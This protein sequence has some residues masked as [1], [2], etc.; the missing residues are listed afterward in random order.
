MSINVL[1]LRDLQPDGLLPIQKAYIK[2]MIK[3]LVDAQQ[4]GTMQNIQT[5]PKERGTSPNITTLIEFKIPLPVD[6]LYCPALSCT[7]YD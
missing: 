7:V 3:S 5:Q 4:A 2:F 6:Q 1:G